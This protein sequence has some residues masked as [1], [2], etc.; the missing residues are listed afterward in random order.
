MIRSRDDGGG[1]RVGPITNDKLVSIRRTVRTQSCRL[2][3]P[4]QPLLRSTRATRALKAFGEEVVAVL[5][6]ADLEIVIDEDGADGGDGAVVVG[7]GLIEADGEHAGVKA[8]GAE[9]GLLGED[10]AL[11]G[12][13]LL[14]IG[15]LV[16]GDG[17]GAEAVDF[18]DVLEADD[19]K[20]GGVEDVLAGVL[21]GSG[22]ALRGAGSSGEFG[23]GAIG[24]DVGFC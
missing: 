9:E 18:V 6:A 3:G 20:G 15:G 1:W 2:T 19:G 8:F 5:S 7:D 16:R 17:I 12:K 23:V 14:G 10:D 4:L 13:G 22:L 11:D 21:R 24:G